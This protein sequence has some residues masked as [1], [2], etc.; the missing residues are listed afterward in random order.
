MPVNTRNNFVWYLLNDAQREFANASAAYAGVTVGKQST[1]I[2]TG[3]AK[4]V[5]HCV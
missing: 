1:N 4:K 5:G 2:Y 3:W